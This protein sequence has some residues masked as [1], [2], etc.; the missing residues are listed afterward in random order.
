MKNIVGLTGL[1]GSGKSL[2]ADF[3]A[4]LGVTIIDTDQISHELTSRGGLAIGAI[5]SE[6]GSAYIK[7]DGS[8]NRD[9]MRQ[10]VF[11]D[12]NA[13]IRLES[14]LHPL[15]FISVVNQVKQDQGLYTIV[16]VPLLF[17]SQRYLEYVTRSIF[18]DCKINLLV[19]RVMK[20]SGLTQKEVLD[21][22]KTQVPRDVQLNMADD[23]LNNSKTLSCLEGEVYKLHQQYQ[24]LFKPVLG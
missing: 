9:L 12:S 7:T 2:A 3:F 8:L 20:R 18:V 15:I 10:L 17:K 22:V 24:K 13:R 11:V 14:I 16:V 21:I 1:I 19:E 5:Q 4:R 23:I 6:F